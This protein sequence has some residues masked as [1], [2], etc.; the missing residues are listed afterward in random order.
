MSRPAAD[1][2][3]LGVLVTRP[4]HQ[5]PGLCR[6]IA[7][8]RGRPLAFPAMEILPVA[9]PG[10]ARAL[11]AQPWDLAIYTSA[12]AVQHAAPL[13]PSGGLPAAVRLAAVGAATA[14][15]LAGLGRPAD[16][17]PG[18]FDSEGL[19]A[20]PQLGSP[21]GLRVLIV[22]GQGGRALLG[23]TLAERGAQVYFAEV[24]RR[25]LPVVDVAPLLARWGQDVQVVSVTSS[26]VLEGM[27]RLMGP[28]G[29]TRLCATPLVVISE[30]TRQAAV[31]FGVRRVESASGA[32]DASQ[33]AVLLRLA[34]EVVP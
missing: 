19:L 6:L 13:A 2:R 18:R 30:R 8:H 25:A 16:L 3:G 21:Q 7:D 28:E 26:E 32:D 5:A 20:L 12:N 1:L 33:L 11:L 15:A 17:L 14:Q 27:I 31:A 22:R 24:Y 34:G 23:E 10:P 29:R 4:A 9:D